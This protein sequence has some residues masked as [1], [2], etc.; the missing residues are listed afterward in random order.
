M[1]YPFHLRCFASEA[2]P[3]VLHL[4]HELADAKGAKA[5]SADVGRGGGVGAV[6][7][8]TLAKSTQTHQPTDL[9]HVSKVWVG[10]GIAH[11]IAALSPTQLT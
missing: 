2:L 4:D 10:T 9:G 11:W 7:P 5:A 1:G 3:F 6:A 8:G